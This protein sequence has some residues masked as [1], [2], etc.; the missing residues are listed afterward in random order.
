MYNLSSPRI[1]HVL[2]IRMFDISYQS[3]FIF[4]RSAIGQ[5]Q[6]DA[7]KVLHEF[8]DNVIRERRNEIMRNP[9]N[10]DNSSED[11]S[12]IKSKM[13]FLDILLHASI[14]GKPLTDLDIREEVDT[15]MFEVRAMINCMRNGRKRPCVITLC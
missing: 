7:L 9:P 4:N 8:T 10:F 1:T 11:D 5:R 14:D 12:G 15:F 13:A 2:H 6:R 3:D